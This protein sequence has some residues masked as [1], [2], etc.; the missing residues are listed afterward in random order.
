[1]NT[2]FTQIRKIPV[3]LLF[4][5]ITILALSASLV[6]VY[7]SADITEI[8]YTVFDGYSILV[9]IALIITFIRYKNKCKSIFDKIS[10]KKLM[11]STIAF[12]LLA[13]IAMI[14]IGE[15]YPIGDCMDVSNAGYL[16][17]NGKVTEFLNVD[18][19]SIYPNNLGIVIYLAFIYKIVGY[20]SYAVVQLINILW[21]LIIVICLSGITK[22]ITE[23]VNVQK[24]CWILAMFFFPMFFHSLVIYNDIVGLSFCIISVYFCIRYLKEHRALFFFLLAI[25]LAIGYILRANNLIV[26]VAVCIVLVLEFFIKYNYKSLIKVLLIILTVFLLNLTMIKGIEKVTGGNYHNGYPLIS[27]VVMGLQETAMQPG[28]FNGYYNHLI[29][30]VNEDREQAKILMDQE[31]SGRINALIS[32][33]PYLL[34]FFSRKLEA[35]WLEPTFQA[36]SASRNYSIGKNN[37][38]DDI[39]NG[40]IFHGLHIF[41]NIFQSFVYCFSSYA[42]FSLMKKKKLKLEEIIIPII[43]VGG[44]LFHIFWEAKTRYTLPYFTLLIPLGAIGLQ[45]LLS[46]HSFSKENK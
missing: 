20:E 39:F 12:Y 45:Y 14:F 11:I 23:N 6:T 22:L 1:M 15:F 7:F 16:L 44:F 18:H 26:I 21:T 17:A 19:L 34:D 5:F 27:W 42:L 2:F 32:N 43:V 37:F 24:L 25:S 31:L 4:L 30:S 28:W 40:Y 9:V 36:F 3:V 13:G 8:T 33:P 38:V 41:L 10:L 35:I 46:K 29:K